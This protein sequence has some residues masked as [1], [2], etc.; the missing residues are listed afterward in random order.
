MAELAL[1]GDE[2]THLLSWWRPAESAQALASRPR[3]RVGVC[4]EAVNPRRRWDALAQF[5]APELADDRRPGRAQ[6]ATSTGPVRA[7]PGCADGCDRTHGAG[8]DD[9]G[10]QRCGEAG[11]PSIDGLDMVTIEHTLRVCG[12]DALS[13]SRCSPTG[14]TQ[15]TRTVPPRPSKESHAVSCAVTRHQP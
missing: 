15:V 3:L 7:R 1:T 8:G 9:A 4:G 5:T 11:V 6:P 12:A 10:G 2:R 14:L 13:C